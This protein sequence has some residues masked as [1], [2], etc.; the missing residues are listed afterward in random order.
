MGKD[1]KYFAF[2]SYKREDEKIARWLQ[3]KLEHYKLPNSIRKDNSYLPKIIRP[4]FKDTTDL[5]GGVLEKAIKNALSS[6]KYLIVICSPRAAQSLWVCKE[7]QEFIESGR[8]E[9]IIPFIIDG[10]PHSTDSSKECFP[11]GL[12]ELSGSRELLGISIHEM[13]REAAVIK[14]VARMFDL[15]FDELWRRFER[16]KKV[17][18]FVGFILLACILL[19]TQCIYT[20]VRELTVKVEIEK[21]EKIFHKLYSDYLN[22]NE[23]LIKQ[24]YLDAFNISKEILNGNDLQDDTLTSKF[25]YVLRTCYSAIQSDTL[26]ITNRYTANFPTMDWG[27]MPVNFSNRGDTIYVGC[28]GFSIIEAN[29]GKNILQKEFWPSDFRVT[30]DEVYC[31]DDFQVDIYNKADLKKIRGFNLSTSIENYQHYLGSSIDGGRICTLD[32]NMEVCNVYDTNTGSVINS[33]QVNGKASINYNGKILAYTENERLR[34]YNI[35]TG[36]SIETYNDLYAVDSQFDQSGKWLLL[37]LEKYEIVNVLDLETDQMYSIEIPQL[38]KKWY[39]S[40]CFSGHAFANKYII[41]DDNRFLAIG[42]EIYDMADN[43]LFKKI[44]SADKAVGIKIMPNAKKVIQVNW[45]NEIIV[46]TRNGK[47]MFEVVSVDF[48]TLINQDQ[49][50]KKYDILISAGG[51]ITIKNKNGE[52]L[53]EIKGIN[54]DIYHLSISQDEKYILISSLAIPT[55]L[56]SLSTG[57]RVQE[58]PFHTGDGDLGFG[59]FGEDGNLYFNSLNAVYKYEL[60]SLEHLCNINLEI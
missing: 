41:S 53:G 15:R 11:S 33:F 32:S 60:M 17:K 10:E 25:E 57:N 19:I 34:L 46:Y 58:F 1:Y 47:P 44:D 51:D 5:S 52:L 16:S 18:R 37:N 45:D 43:S 9:Y 40:F 7:V 36:Q 26:K 6:S 23:L 3:K 56:Y 50:D 4:I 13:G 38:Q 22:C 35:D 48:Q 8:E 49:T 21:K 30:S 2:I 24:K 29:T 55:S 28:S 31:F 54:G 39:S 14:V 20:Y 12:R 59:V 42:G 27:D